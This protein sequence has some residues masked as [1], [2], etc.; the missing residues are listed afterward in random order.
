MLM[1]LAPGGKYCRAV[2]LQDPFSWA[3]HDRS[4]SPYY[5]LVTIVDDTTG[6][7]RKCCI[8][9]TFLEGAVMTQMRLPDELQSM[10]KAAR[11]IIENKSRTYHFSNPK[12]LANVEPRYSEEQ[13]AAARERLKPYTNED[14]L[15][16][17]QSDQS[18]LKLNSLGLARDAVAC[19]LLERGLYARLGDVPGGVYALSPKDIAD[20]QRQ[21]AKWRENARQES[22]RAHTLACHLDGY[23]A[24]AE[25]FVLVDSDIG[26]INLLQYSLCSDMTRRGPALVDGARWYDPIINEKPKYDWNTFLENYHRSGVAAARQAWLSAWKRKSHGSLGFT[27]FGGS[28]MENGDDMAIAIKAWRRGGLVGLPRFQYDLRQGREWVGSVYLDTSGRQAL[29]Y[30]AGDP[31]ANASDPNHMLP[32]QLVP[33]NR[34]AQNCLGIFFRPVNGIEDYFVI[35]SRAR[36]SKQ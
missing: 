9:A 1:L 10:D 35:E 2:S 22:W 6:K 32:P 36:H 23:H 29:A 24:L 21:F 13:L 7:S 15:G 17:P 16:R 18:R 30:N 11:T 31:E 3:I 26:D 33:K 19:V 12:A 28:G 25:K 5:L 14:L 34:A 27:S 20:E 4:T 8:C